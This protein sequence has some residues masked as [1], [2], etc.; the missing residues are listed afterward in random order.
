[1]TTLARAVTSL[2]LLLLVSLLPTSA[3]SPPVPGQRG[4]AASLDLSQSA[5]QPTAA[6]GQD[7]IFF[8]TWSC[9]SLTTPCEGATITDTLPPQLSRAAA[10]VQFSGN[11]A[12]V[13]YDPATGT[14]V[15]TVFSPLPA[16]RSSESPRPRPSRCWL[17]GSGTRTR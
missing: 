11:F 5:S 2:A 12:D 6:T 13:A 7:F 8:L 3:A 9:A 10:D 16:G 1:M 4:A 14:A 17:T 15:F